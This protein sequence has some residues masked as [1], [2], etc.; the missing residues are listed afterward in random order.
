[1]NLGISKISMYSIIA[2]IMFFHCIMAF[3]WFVFKNI[4]IEKTHTSD[5][6]EYYRCKY[7]I[8]YNLRYIL[9]INI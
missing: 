5:Y 1:M 8:S 9:L 4:D 7:P 3:F 2:L 6:E